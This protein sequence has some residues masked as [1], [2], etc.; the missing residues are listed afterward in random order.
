[1]SYDNFSDIS[2]EDYDAFMKDIDDNVLNDTTSVNNT[3][4]VEL[5]AS[6]MNNPVDMVKL[7][8][9][10]QLI[11]T[12]DGLNNLHRCTKAWV[13]FVEDENN[14]MYDMDMS[15]L[16]DDERVLESAGYKYGDSVPAYLENEISSDYNNY[17]SKEDRLNSIEQASLERKHKMFGMVFDAQKE[18]GDVCAFD[19]NT[20]EYLDNNGYSDYIK[21]LPDNEIKAE[22]SR[23]DTQR[24]ISQNISPIYVGVDVGQVE[25]SFNNESDRLSFSAIH[26]DAAKPAVKEVDESFIPE[27]SDSQYQTN[28]EL[29]QDRL[30]AR[31]NY[32]PDIVTVYNR[33]IPNDSWSFDEYDTD[34]RSFGD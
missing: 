29:N 3:D 32:K 8:Q 20:L 27:I 1:M 21:S 24:N 17:D 26:F 9:D 31:N 12:E 7:F 16:D 18:A 2:Y 23:R 11:S 6:H 22:Q 34:D 19:N 28:N 13:A 10:K 25:P 33:A 14:R 5:Q 30:P 4:S 15:I